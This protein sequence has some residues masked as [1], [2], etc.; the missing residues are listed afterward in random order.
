MV[1]LP[2]YDICL[3]FTGQ[4][5]A[6]SSNRIAGT[7]NSLMH[8]KRNNILFVFNT[9][10]GYVSEGVYLHTYLKGLPINLTMHCVGDVASI[11]IPIFLS[12]THRL[13]SRYSR[14]LIHPT[15]IPAQSGPVDARALL[16]SLH[17]ATD[18]DARVRDILN[19][20]ECVPTD[21]VDRSLSSEVIIDPGQALQ[22]GLVQEVKEFQ[23]PPGVDALQI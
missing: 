8:E 11:G 9:T 17:R 21:V 18:G 5:T 3:N 23:L 22:W 12:A 13:C 20:S 15:A 14:F 16:D 19:E 10:G 4:I 2:E 1:E 6:E 7:I